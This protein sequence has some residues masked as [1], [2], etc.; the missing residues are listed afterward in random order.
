MKLALCGLFLFAQIAHAGLEKYSSL[1]V[2]DKYP[3]TESESNAIRVTYLGVNGFQFETGGHALLVDPY[4]TRVALFSAALNHRIE[5]NPGRV[6]EG[7]RHVQ[8][9]VDA[10]LVTHAHFDH[11]LDVPEIM[12]RT[13]AQLL[14]GPTAIRLVE[15]F[16]ISPNECQIVKPASTRKIGPWTI[17]VFAAQHDRL[18]GK[19]PFDKC[20]PTTRSEKIPTK[21]SDWCLGEPLAFVIEAAGKRIYIDSGGVPGSPP[22]SRTKNVDLAILGVALPD[23]RQRFAEAARQLRPRY[24][25]PSHQDDMFAPVS[26]GFTFGK[27]TNFPELVRES[28]RKDS[29]GRLILLDYFRPWTLR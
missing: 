9:R 11:L 17:R 15:S 6:N 1:V 25:S 23:S 14:A 29:P 8:R 10:V 28:K 12:R 5:S 26:R 3:F 18:F 7:L 27:M 16:G 13:H 4:F 19:V 22:E 2:A 20:P 21:A 24:L